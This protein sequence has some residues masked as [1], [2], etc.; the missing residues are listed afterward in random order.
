[1]AS[2]ARRR[3]VDHRIH[4]IWAITLADDDVPV[5]NLLL[6]PLPLS[7]GVVKNATDDIEI[8][9]HL[10]PDVWGRG[11]ATEAARAVVD[12][13]FSRGTLRILA[14]T[15]PDNLASQAVC[16][17]LG[18]TPRGRTDRYYDTETELFEIGRRSTAP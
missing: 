13:A 15:H 8:G 2:I 12:D 3:S 18:M 16:R 6:K 14:V 11:F 5:G 4:G 10:H 17:R 9:W 7:D 1:M